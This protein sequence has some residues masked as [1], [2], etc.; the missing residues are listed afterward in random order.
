MELLSHQKHRVLG[1]NHGVEALALFRK[2]RPDLVI[3][4]IMMPAMDGVEFVRRL[5]ADPATATIPIII[6]TA[7]YNER[8]AAALARSCGISNVLTKPC[9]PGHVLRTV[10]A[11][12]RTA[13]NRSSQSLPQEFI[14]E[15]LP[16][17][18]DKASQTAAYPQ[19]SSQR[20]AALV[21]INRQLVSEQDQQ[22]LLKSVCR[23]ARRL[24]GAEYAALAVGAG[25]NENEVYFFTSGMSS[26]CAKA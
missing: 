4:D 6:F 8:E 15:D 16:V 13:P 9:T 10:E 19:V 12:L 26:G 17:T 3:T 22:Q 24:L 18:D 2:R 20:L 21:D 14:Q 7:E 23:A 11:V 1:A 5:R 25:A